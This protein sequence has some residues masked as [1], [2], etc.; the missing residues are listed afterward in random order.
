MM[1]P[2]FVTYFY[3]HSRAKVL[4]FLSDFEMVKI[5]SK[6]VFNHLRSILIVWKLL[7]GQRFVLEC[8]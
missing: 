4:F 8:F 3:F 2:G 7:N 1:K 5:T 6:L